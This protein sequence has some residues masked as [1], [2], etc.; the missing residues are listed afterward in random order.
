MNFRDDTGSER[1][2]FFTSDLHL[3][4]ANVI[5]YCNR[6]FRNADEMNEKIIENWNSVVT[7]QDIVYIV[8]DV[9][10]EKDENKRIWLLNRLKGEKHLI[11][12]N[13]DRII[14]GRTAK[15]FNHIENSG[16]REIK[17]PDLDGWGGNQV[18]VMCH[19]PLLTW[20]K[21]HYG[22]Y[23]LHGHCHGTLKEDPNSRRF[24]VGVDCWDFTP[25]SYQQIKDKMT[26]KNWKPVDHHGEEDE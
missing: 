13:H 16:L 8:G 2:R 21:G 17:V 1:Q 9:I 5:K 25:V 19:Y 26:K 10:F 22:S 6:P 11:K 14:T 4:H 3:S 23:M 7:P 15:C 20:N 12:G 24:D 18:I